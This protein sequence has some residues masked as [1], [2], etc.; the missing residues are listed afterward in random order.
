VEPVTAPAFSVLVAAYNQAEWVEETLDTVAAQRWADYELVVVDDGSTDGTG[1]RVARWIER[2]R[3]AH[4]NRAVLEATENRGQSAAMEHGFS[5][6]R[7]RW[8]CL[9]DSDDRWLPD[10]LARLAEAASADPAAGMIVHPLYVI[11][12]HGRRTGDVRPKRARLSAGDLRQEIRRT[13]RIVAPASSGMA[14]RA[15]VFAS[16]LP[17][18]IKGFRTAADMY[19]ALGA[20]LLA[21]VCALD[22]PLGEYR[23]HADGQHVRTMLSP[24]GLG[25][26]VEL[27]DTLVRHFGLERAARRGN[28]YFVRHEFA[29]A[30]LRG[31]AAEQS[32][33]W[34]R[35]LGATWRDESFGVRERVLFTGYWTACLLSPRPVFRRLWR[36]FQMKQTGF[37]RIGL[38]ST[39]AA[40]I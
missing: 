6:C 14:L 31:G 28:S 32:S 40:G 33:A 34:A 9:L 38:G 11:D 10:K 4:P 12:S 23:M 15:D 20:G 26:W 22:E 30:K 3:H 27:Q 18:P 2:F 17:M 5:L 35:L 29:L 16:L 37:D 8:I 21:N 36:A 1:E 25:R 7:G 13:S 24:E 39:R 19:L